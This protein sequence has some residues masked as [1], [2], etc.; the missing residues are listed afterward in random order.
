MKNIAI[1]VAAG[2]GSRIGGDIPKQF[3]KIDGKEILLYS[4]ET[5]SQCE[6]IDEIVL[7]INKDYR[8]NYEILVNG[9]K[10]NNKVILVDG[11][12]TRQ[13]SVKNAVEKVS[14][15]EEDAIVL[16]HDA[17]RPFVSERI[18]QDNI[19]AVKK[20]RCCTTAIQ[21]TNSIYMTNEGKFVNEVNRDQVY[22]AQTPQSA[23]LH[24]FKKAYESIKE[25]CTDEAALFAKLGYIPHIVQ[26]EEKNKKI[27][28]EED[29][30][31]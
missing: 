10:N 2:T 25:I 18:I 19:E 16:V 30:K 6:L 23:Y 26:G 5:F 24:I 9:I 11:G 1:I 13:E 21:S 8:D 22:I 28:F 31:K 12:E 20:S 3:L 27:T 29:L 15:S 4:L 14:Q 17:A 7:V